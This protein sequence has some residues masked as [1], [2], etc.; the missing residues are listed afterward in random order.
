MKYTQAVLQK[1]WLVQKI[2]WTNNWVVQEE[3]IWYL[4]YETKLSYIIIPKWFKSNFWSVPRLLRW[5]VSPTEFIWFVS[6]DFLYSKNAYI[7]IHL[8][9]W[10]ENIFDCPELKNM[11]KVQANWK[12]YAIPDRLFADK[13]LDKQIIVEKWSFYKRLLIYLAVR[14]FWWRHFKKKW[15]KNALILM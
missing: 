5:I 2:P 7:E 11:C 4:N 13:T 10:S 9:E 8:K 12:I 14:L 15:I 1:N 6:H 3:F